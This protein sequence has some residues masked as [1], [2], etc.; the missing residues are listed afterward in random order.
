MKL[1]FEQYAL[2][3]GLS[4]FDLGEPALH[5]ANSRISRKQWNRL[6]ERQKRADDIWYSK[7]QKLRSEY[8]RKVRSGEIEPLTRRERLEAIANGHPDNESVQAARRILKKLNEE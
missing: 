7:R 3:H 6:I 4:L 5:K 1:T 8:D 2:K